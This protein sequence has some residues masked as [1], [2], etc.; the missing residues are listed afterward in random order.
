[1]KVHLKKKLKTHP[2]LLKIRLMKPLGFGPRAGRTHQFRIG[3]C[4][5]LILRELPVRRSCYRQNKIFIWIGFRKQR[6]KFLL[7]NLQLEYYFFHLRL[8]SQCVRV[9]GRL[10]RNIQRPVTSRQ[11]CSQRRNFV[12][13]V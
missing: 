3:S 8:R 11:P 9:V 1:M 13:E 10:Q 6:I 5:H 2:S 7:V 12:V 4:V